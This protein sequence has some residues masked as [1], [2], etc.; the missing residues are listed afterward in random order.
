[1][2]FNQQE[3]KE[4]IDDQNS[5]TKSLED[6]MEKFDGNDFQNNFEIQLENRLDF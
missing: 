5:E 6:F 2:E 1:M 3:V 4:V